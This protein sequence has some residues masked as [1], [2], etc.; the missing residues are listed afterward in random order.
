[1]G[2]N[3]SGEYPAINIGSIVRG[4]GP[5]VKNFNLINNGPSEAEIEIRLF[6]LE[7]DLYEGKNMFN[8]QFNQPILG[9]EDLI[10]LFFNPI[11]P[12]FIENDPFINISPKKTKIKGRSLE[13]FRVE[14]FCD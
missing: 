13:Q 2:I 10:K 12:K 4:T 8:V 7:E 11:E 9:S 14:F 3:L 1:M 5:I 6:K